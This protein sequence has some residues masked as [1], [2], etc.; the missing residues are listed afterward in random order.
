M[1]SLVQGVTVLGVEAIPVGVEAEIISSLRRFSIVGL[2]DGIVKEAKDRVRC[3]IENSG[4]EF[5]TGEVIVSLSPASLPKMGSGF[6][7]AIAISILS[8]Q[9]VL[10]S[11]VLSEY[12]FV[13]EL[14]LDGGIRAVGSE[15]ASLSL[16]KDLEGLTLVTSSEAREVLSYFPEISSCYVDNLSDLVS[17]IRLGTFYKEDIEQEE[18]PVECKSNFN[19]DPFFDVVGQEVAKRALVVAAAGGHNVLMVGPPGSG[20][21]MLA[22]RLSQLLPDLNRDELMEVNKIYGVLRGSGLTSGRE[23][24][25][26]TSRPFRSPHHSMSVAGLI[27]GGSNPTPG[28]VTLAHRGVLFLDEFPELR[29]DALECLREPLENRSISITRA[30]F[31]LR[32]PSDFILIAAMNPCPCGKRGS[33]GEVKRLRS[34]HIKKCECSEQVVKRYVG[35][36]SAPILDRIDIQL[37]VSVVP[38]SSIHRT[39]DLNVGSSCQ[40]PSEVVRR[41]RQVQRDRFKVGTMLNSSMKTSDIKKYCKLTADAKNLLEMVSEKYELSTRAY[42]RILKLGKTISDI[43]E[44]SEISVTH[45]SEAISYRVDMLAHIS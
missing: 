35:R 12:V 37:W 10:S 31:R 28:E 7:V 5:P 1:G 6:D 25:I 22:E 17:S 32:Y 19:I 2:P 14:A 29:R 44:S 24:G 13:G 30:K 21:T 41:V 16:V 4:F 27:G 26:I 34:T 9:G 39:G 40:T 20:K 15:V 43:D 8:A 38:A 18:L 3:A 42:T 23:E 33:N 45:I 11:E 36:I